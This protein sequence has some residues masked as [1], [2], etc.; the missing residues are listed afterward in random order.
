[1]TIDEKVYP[2]LCQP[3]LKSR[4]WGGRHLETLFGIDLPNGEK[5]G[6]AWMAA[7][8]AEGAS[9]IANGSHQGKTLSEVTAL[10]G[11]GMIGSAWRGKPTGGRFPLLI[12]FLDARD[13]LS[14]QVH[15]DARACRREFPND[16]PKDES[17]IVIDTEPGARILHGFVRGTTLE[18][19]DRLLAEGRVIECIRSIEPKPGDVFRVAPGTVHALCQG[20]VLLEIQ[21]PSDSTFR[22]YDYGRLGADGKPRALHIDAARRVMRFLDSDLPAGM[23]PIATARRWGT[24]EILVDVEAYRIERIRAKRSLEWEIDPRSAQVVVMLAG[25]GRIQ[26]AGETVPMKKG[27]CV[28]LPAALGSVHLE[29]EQEAMECVLAGAGEIEMIRG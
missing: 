20:V 8:L 6:E 1:M 9:W 25:S 22:I 18:D 17:W 26:G 11:E 27:A 12:K 28:I 2:L 23:E 15:P 4:I 29:V 7:D 3:V 14:V 13:D 21:E 16:F 10:W 24:Q 19:V 5:I